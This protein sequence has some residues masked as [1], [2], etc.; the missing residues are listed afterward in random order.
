LKNRE[1]ESKFMM[2]D[3]LHGIGASPPVEITISS[4]ECLRWWKVAATVAED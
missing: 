4:R 2:M 3:Q 1:Y